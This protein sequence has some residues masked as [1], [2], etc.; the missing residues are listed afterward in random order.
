MGVTA[1]LYRLANQGRVLSTRERGVRVLADLRAQITDA[2]EPVVIDFA[3]VLHASYSFI[4]EFIGALT[5]DAESMHAP[6]PRLANVPP[7][8]KRVVDRTLRTRGL[9]GRAL[10][11]A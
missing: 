7:S 9:P 11:S 1:V 2:D 5:E 8:V 6:V 10:T 3:G 4:D